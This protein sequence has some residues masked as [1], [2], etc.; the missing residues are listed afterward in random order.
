MVTFC[1]NPAVAVKLTDRFSVGLGV[2]FIYSKLT[3]S[4]TQS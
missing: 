2:S 3:Q 1:V 4:I